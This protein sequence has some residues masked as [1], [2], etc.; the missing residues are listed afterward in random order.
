MSQ[1]RRSYDVESRVY[2]VTT[3][4]YHW[5]KWFQNTAYANTSA[6]Q[7]LHLEKRK[8]CLIIAY[9]VMP[10]HLHL[11]LEIIGR[12]NISELVHDLKSRIA[13]EISLSD[14]RGCHASPSTRSVA[15]SGMGCNKIASPMG[16]K[17]YFRIWQRSFYDRGIRDEQD[18]ENHF[19]YVHWNPVKH[20]YVQ[21]P[22]DWPWSS[23]H[24]Y[25]TLGLTD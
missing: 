11:L 24:K 5:V 1:I 8:D 19:Q 10:D 25:K 18:L 6:Q 20:G 2:F 9:V 21:N 22:W 23:Y 4:T 16:E 12:K 13:Y 14:R 17:K 7:I 15:A 3:N